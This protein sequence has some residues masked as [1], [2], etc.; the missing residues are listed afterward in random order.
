MKTQYM[1]ENGGEVE[2]SFVENL[3]NDSQEGI[4]LK[5]AQKSD[6]VRHL[7][8]CGCFYSTAGRCH[9]KMT[10]GVCSN[11]LL[12]HE[13]GSTTK[14]VRATSLQVSMSSGV[15]RKCCVKTNN[16]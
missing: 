9:F 13:G 15:G 10:L 4:G 11:S 6:V 5:F 3:R 16:L 1:R 2:C 14:N 12:D 8:S 7:F